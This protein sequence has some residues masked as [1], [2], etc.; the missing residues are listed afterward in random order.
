MTMIMD[1][2][3]AAGQTVRFIVNYF[4]LSSPNTY[5]I[6]WPANWSLGRAKKVDCETPLPDVDCLM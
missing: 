6:A 4:L 2:A 3:A 1:G 5:I